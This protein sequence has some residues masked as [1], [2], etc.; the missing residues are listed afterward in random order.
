M[1][2]RNKNKKHGSYVAFSSKKCHMET[3]KGWIF[4]IMRYKDD[5]YMELPQYELIGKWNG[6]SYVAV[7][8]TDI[9]FAGATKE[10]VKQ[11]QQLNK[12]VKK[13]AKSIQR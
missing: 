3:G 4:S 11:Y 9:Q 6:I 2:K 10:A 13:T 7:F 12:S 1:I 8:P 5:T